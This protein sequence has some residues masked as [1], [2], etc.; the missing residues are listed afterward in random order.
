MTDDD[1]LGVHVADLGQTAEP[2]HQFAAT[3]PGLDD[4]QVWRR[5]ALIIFHCRGEAAIEHLDRGARHAAVAGCHVDG[6][7]DDLRFAE[8]LNRDARHQLDLVEIAGRR[9]F[10][11]HRLMHVQVFLQLI[12]HFVFPNKFT[13][14]SPSGR[15]S[16]FEFG[17]KLGRALTPVLDHLSTLG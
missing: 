8:G 2:G 10:R 16:V 7:R 6:L 12:G 1:Y 3:Q 9:A 13:L 14:S 17:Y 4:D 15:R 5:R 11:G